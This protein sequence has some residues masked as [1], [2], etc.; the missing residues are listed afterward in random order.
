MA[1]MENIAKSKRE[2]RRIRID[3]H[4]KNGIYFLFVDR[5][6]SDAHPWWLTLFEYLKS[7]VCGDLEWDRSTESE[8]LVAR[9][10]LTKEQ[11]A[12]I[13]AFVRTAPASEVG[14]HRT[15]RLATRMDREQ[16]DRLELMCFSDCEQ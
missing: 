16:Q 15:L 1:A 12:G 5:S 14:G 11:R 4:A 13:A 7:L 9:P 3:L 2:I 10:T 8:V 6:G